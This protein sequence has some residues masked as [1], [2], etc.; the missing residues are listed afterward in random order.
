[1]RCCSYDYK[2]ATPTPKPVIEKGTLSG[3]LGGSAACGGTLA[4]DSLTALLREE[5]MKRSI[6]C[7]PLERVLILVGNLVGHDQHTTPNR[8]DGPGV[9]FD[10]SGKERP[11][12]VP[13]E[14][15]GLAFVHNH[16]P[17]LRELFG[18]KTRQPL[19]SYQVCGGELPAGGQKGKSNLI[20][21]WWE[22]RLRHS[23]TSIR[24]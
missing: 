1:M 4:H 12:C 10:P 7:H 23:K 18:G 19:S 3:R 9:N 15:P 16:R 20:A 5:M 13:V 14:V 2:P 24:R 21:D 11:K 22:L 8:V 17:D 6:A